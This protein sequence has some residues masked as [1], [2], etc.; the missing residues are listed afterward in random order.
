MQ[1]KKGNSRDFCAGD[2]KEFVKDQTITR[3][4]VPT[5]TSATENRASIKVANNTAVWKNDLTL[6]VSE[7]I[8]EIEKIF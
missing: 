8:E 2:E 7:A 1:A 6:W 5:R 3:I 4:E